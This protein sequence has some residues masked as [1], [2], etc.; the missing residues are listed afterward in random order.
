MLGVRIVSKVGRLRGFERL[1]QPL[2]AREQV[3]QFD[4]DGSGQS[5]GRTQQQPDCLLAL[6]PR[7]RSERRTDVHARLIRRQRAGIGAALAQGAIEQRQY[8]RS[9]QAG[10]F[11]R[12]PRVAHYTAPKAEE[13]ARTPAQRSAIEVLCIR[14]LIRSPRSRARS[15]VHPSQ[16]WA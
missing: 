16:R 4:L 8:Q 3:I 10:E 5:A 12:A 7:Q 14:G 6:G 1:A 11:Q 2:R 9:G 13:P 15:K